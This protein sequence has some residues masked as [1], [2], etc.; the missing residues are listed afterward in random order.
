MS[1]LALSAAAAT[2]LL[3]LSGCMATP[4]ATTASPAP[5]GEQSSAAQPVAVELPS[6][7]EFMALDEVDAL[8]VLSSA[9]GQRI[10]ENSG[11]DLLNGVWFACDATP[12][13]P[14]GEIIEELT[15]GQVQASEAPDGS[16]DA[17]HVASTQIGG[18]TFPG[19][20]GGFRVI[21]ADEYATFL[22][23][24]GSGGVDNP[25]CGILL[26]RDLE[27]TDYIRAYYSASD[28]AI[29]AVEC[30]DT[31]MVAVLRQTGQQEPTG[32]TATINGF[33]CSQPR[34]WMCWTVVDGVLW[35]SATQTGARDMPETAQDAAD[36][37]R[38]VLAAQ[39]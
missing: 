33:S 4:A 35:S 6:C 25:W 28:E 27:S 7:A 1:R 26:Q 24:H 5:D 19:Q 12:D 3:I 9:T 29:G 18:V 22:A 17:K 10:D 30:R 11:N 13:R 37:L 20:A 2:M 39:P 23:A 34:E 21:P 15:G 36:V 14:L 16:D 8:G 32:A 31:R 38:D